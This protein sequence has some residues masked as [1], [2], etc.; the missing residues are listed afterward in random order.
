MKML[1][2]LDGGV[3]FVGGSGVEVELRDFPYTEV[4][5]HHILRVHQG[6]YAE[7]GLKTR[8]FLDC[9]K[10]VSRHLQRI[11]VILECLCCVSVDV[12]RHLIEK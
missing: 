7:Q 10:H 1:F 2:K 6:Y 5:V 11:L 8:H 12:T 3:A 4:N 9:W